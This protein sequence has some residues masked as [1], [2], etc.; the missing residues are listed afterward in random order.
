MAFQGCAGLQTK[1]RLRLRTRLG[2]SGRNAGAA[3]PGRRPRP[4]HKNIANLHFSSECWHMFNTWKRIVSGVDN[5]KKEK[6][7]NTN[8]PITT[9][10]VSLQMLKRLQQVRTFRIASASPGKPDC[11]SATIL[12]FFFNGV[13]T[14]LVHRFALTHGVCSVS[15][16]KK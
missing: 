6:A 3:S 14:A 16:T 11:T 1:E 15:H 8:P 9:Q 2:H 5:A 12:S 13:R 4:K 10:W 7:K